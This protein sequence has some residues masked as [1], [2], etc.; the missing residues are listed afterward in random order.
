MKFRTFLVWGGA[1][2]LGWIF[3]ATT[4]MAQPVERDYVV[5]AGD[6]LNIQVYSQVLL[7]PEFSGTF[8]VRSDRMITLPS[9]LGDIRV[10]GLKKTTLARNL[11]SVDVLGKYVKEPRVTITPTR[12]APTIRV[13]VSGVFPMEQDIPRES[14]LTTIL[15]DLLPKLQQYRPDVQAIHVKS[16]E[17]EE[18]SMAQNPRLQWGDEIIIPSLVLPTPPPISLETPTLPPAIFTS[19]QYQQFLEFLAP[20]PADL[21]ILKTVVAIQ[22]DMVTLQ[23]DQLSEDQQKSLQEPVLAE[24]MK[25]TGGGVMPDVLLNVTLLEIMVNLTVE[26]LHEAFLAI[27]DP[28]APLGVTIRSFRQGDVVQPGATEAEQISLAEIQPEL[29]QVRLQQGN[30]SQTL[31][32]APKFS[33][34]TLSGILKIGGEREVVL[35]N[36]ITDPTSTLGL[37]KRYKIGD[38]VAADILLADITPEQKMVVLQK[39][40]ELQLLFLRDPR[41]RPVST[42]PA[43]ATPEAMP[44]AENG[45]P[46]AMPGMPTDAPPLSGP[47]DMTLQSPVLQNP[48]NIQIRGDEE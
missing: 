6:T 37:R 26:G 13:V 27:P 22:E 7:M 9:L 14:Q 31:S 28:D 36:T 17:G 34:M 43:S 35:S 23:L 47:L 48:L 4:I 11:E 45:Q 42:P 12:F 16:V 32:L 41:K 19:Q 25:Y 46:I 21:D 15:N 18:F 40:A 39:G 29:N 10:A 33:T 5:A 44:I 8:E 30:A 1:A 3:G 38:Q 24:L 20:Y 2:L